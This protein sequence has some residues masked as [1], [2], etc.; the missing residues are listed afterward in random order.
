MRIKSI[1]SSSMLFAS[2][3]LCI[4]PS[5]EAQVSEREKR[6]KE[7]ER[8]QQLERKAYVLAEE[9]AN[10]ALSL[11]LPE[12]RSYLLANSAD[13]LW[14]HDNARARNLYWDALNTL[15]LM[16]TPNGNDGTI[17]DA[18]PSAKEN[19]RD[20][21]FIFRSLRCATVLR[22]VARRDPQLA[23]EMYAIRAN[24]RLNPSLPTFLFPTTATWSNGSQP[25]PSR[26]IQSELCSWRVRVWRRVSRFNCSTSCTS[27]IA[28][29]RTSGRS[30]PATSLTN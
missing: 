4:A 2:L 19:Q 18:K 16:I 17:K 27:S 12:N 21:N 24:R 7:L 30:L 1:I 15:P 28:E 20:R 29:T 23:L 8:K 10:G 6:E 22:Q 25:K 3:L 11:K 26:E 5:L 13:L 14:D 9:I